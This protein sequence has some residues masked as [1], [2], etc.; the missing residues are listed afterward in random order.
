MNGAL[1]LPRSTVRGCYAAED[2][3]LDVSVAETPAETLSSEC[4]LR[5]VSLSSGHV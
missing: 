3:S 4:S 2:S 5:S 1:I